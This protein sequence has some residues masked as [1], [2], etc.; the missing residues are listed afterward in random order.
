[1]KHLFIFLGTK[2]NKMQCY[3]KGLPNDDSNVELPYIVKEEVI[4]HR[5][6][7]P[8]YGDDRECECGH[9]YYRHF[10]TY[11]DMANVGCKYCGCQEFKEKQT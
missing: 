2:E 6:Y 4:I 8:K 1:M 9:P 10:D 7:N 5:L 3:Y 11:D